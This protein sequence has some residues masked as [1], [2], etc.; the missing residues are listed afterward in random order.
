M[1]RWL[2]E[3]FSWQFQD[4]L[5]HKGDPFWLDYLS[6]RVH[7]CLEILLMF[8]CV[9]ACISCL[10]LGYFKSVCSVQFLRFHYK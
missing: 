1:A 4:V 2:K 6:V 8:L 10:C 5:F 3:C 9:N 7:A